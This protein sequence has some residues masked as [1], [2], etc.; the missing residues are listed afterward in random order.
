MTVLASGSFTSD[1]PVRIRSYR[2]AERED[3][4]ALRTRFVAS[5]Y[6]EWNVWGDWQRLAESGRFVFPLRRNP[7][8]YHYFG[9]A[10]VALDLEREGY[11]CWGSCRIFPNNAKQM[12]DPY[13]RETL[14]VEARLINAGLPLPSSFGP[15]LNFT[16]RNPD[17]VAHHPSLGFRFCEVKT[18]RD[19][20]RRE[21]LQT[22][23]F[24]GHLLGATAEVVRVVSEKTKVSHACIRCEWSMTKNRLGE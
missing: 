2:P 14:A 22:L 15:Q 12:H 8:A 21:Q 24:L 9:E 19:R 16:P 7:S 3:W 5:D 23:A 18:N 10:L 11:T 17:I 1:V 20:L 13:L 6:K 4:R